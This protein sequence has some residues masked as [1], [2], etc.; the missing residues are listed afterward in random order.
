M[1]TVLVCGRQQR[2]TAMELVGSELQ[3]ESANNAINV[4]TDLSYIVHPFIT[5]K[6]WF[7]VDGPMAQQVLK[8][9]DRIPVQF[10][11]AD[12]TVNTLVRSYV[13][14]TRYSFGW[15]DFRFVV[16]SNPS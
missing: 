9:Y 4:H 2:K 13:G 7:V 16:G 10:N 8:W 14:R 5:G 15:A 3:P 12:D 6:K 1:A 11:S